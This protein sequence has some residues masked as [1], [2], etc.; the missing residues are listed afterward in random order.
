MR[1]S[2]RSFLYELI[3]EERCPVCTRSSSL[4]TSPFCDSCWSRIIPFENTQIRLGQFSSSFWEKVD[5]LNFLSYYEGVLKEAINHFKYL[6]VVRIGRELGRILSLIRVPE[7]EIL[8]PVPLHKSKLLK[9]EF[10]QSAILAYELSKAWSIPIEL[11]SL[12]KVKKT[13]DQATLSEKARK[14]NLRDAFSI[15]KP[16]RYRKVGLV[17]DVVTTGATVYECAKVLKEGGALEVHVI[18]LAKTP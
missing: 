13:S 10:N 4:K 11:D 2:L 7:I 3:F 6:G 15:A 16:L 1:L 17:D 12:V 9:R 5:S 18:A 14:S 8:I